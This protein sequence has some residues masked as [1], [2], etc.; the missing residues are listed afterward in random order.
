MMKF[1]DLGWSTNG[2]LSLT[3]PGCVLCFALHIE[4]TVVFSLWIVLCCVQ[5]LQH[6]QHL[7]IQCSREFFCNGVITRLPPLDFVLPC[8]DSSFVHHGTDQRD[9]HASSYQRSGSKGTWAVWPTDYGGNLCTIYHLLSIIPAHA[10]SLQNK[11]EE[12]EALA[13]FQNKFIDACLLTIIE[14]WLTDKETNAKMSTDIFGAPL[15]LDQDT[16]V[17]G[18]WHGEGVCLHVNEQ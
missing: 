10:Q 15:C 4:L 3:L 2:K 7:C 14:T 12:R 18:K 1:C 8:L 13:H 9:A 17:S 16:L 11:T 6:K 5:C